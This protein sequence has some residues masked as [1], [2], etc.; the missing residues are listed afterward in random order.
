MTEVRKDTILLLG[1]Y[2]GV[3]SV[4]ARLLLQETDV[5]IIIAG[6][7]RN[8]ADG[9][10]A[11]LN[12]EFD[13]NRAQGLA[14]DAGDQAGLISACAGVRM[15]V[16]AATTTENL[17]RVA[18][19]ALDA[20]VDFLDIHFEQR[21]FPPLQKL[22]PAIEKADRCFITQ[23]GFHP[24]LPATFVR[25]AALS[26]DRYR[27]AVIGLAMSARVEKPESAYEII[28]GIQ[29]SQA[30]IF[31]DGR[32]RRAG[33][34][35]APRLDFGSKFGVRLC[36]P[37]EMVEI[38]ALPEMLGLEEVGVYAA[39][40]N[41]FVD[42]VV[43]MPG[44]LLGKIKKGLGKHY[45]AKLFV[46]GLKKFSGSKVGVT[47]LLEAEGEKAG[48][49]AKVR[50]LA[51]HADPYFF[52]AAPVV[53]CLLQYLDGSIAKPGLWLMGHLVDP[54]RLL[55]DLQRMGVRIEKNVG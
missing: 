5:N 17:Q 44:L 14:L 13:G 21:A 52:T 49:P 31:K 22:G 3:G 26:F 38:R 41:W 6:R 20:G 50:I 30:E 55:N 32:W 1:G 54:G 29:E 37:I 42:I 8:K 35:D 47:F 36:Y 46:F 4:I 15:V 24:G 2:G 11:R 34:K 25:E 53:A 51:E 7:R 43:L 40:F 10:A 19:T 45:L 23:A 48:K 9:L 12:Q 39:G 28:D 18:R 27:R 16:E 33:Y